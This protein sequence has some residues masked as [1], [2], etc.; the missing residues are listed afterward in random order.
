MG[1]EVVAHCCCDT[2]CPLPP[3]SWPCDCASGPSPRGIGNMW[4]SPDSWHVHLEDMGC[5][6]NLLEDGEAGNG[7]G[8]AGGRAGVQGH[9]AGELQGHVL[10]PHPEGHAWHPVS[11]SSIHSSS[12]WNDNCFDMDCF[13]TFLAGLNLAWTGLYMISFLF[14]EKWQATCQP[15]RKWHLGWQDHFHDV[16]MLCSSSPWMWQGDSGGR[17]HVA[18][19][20]C[21]MW[22][23]W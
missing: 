14:W 23:N 4:D 10:Q 18:P 17:Q 22:T 7:P 2:C 5:P 11:G 1:C 12:R 8:C 6:S 19:S 20:P 16:Y 13:P 15:S 3:H 9:L 21:R